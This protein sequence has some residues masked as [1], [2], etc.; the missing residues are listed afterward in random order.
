MSRRKDCIDPVSFSQTYVERRHLEY[1]NALCKKYGTN[2][3]QELRKMFERDMKD[4]TG[5]DH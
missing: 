3:S 2:K 4:G 1:I 5:P